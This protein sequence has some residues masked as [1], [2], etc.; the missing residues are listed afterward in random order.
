ME[1]LRL[2]FVMLNGLPSMEIYGYVP[3][4]KWF[5]AGIF[6]TEFIVKSLYNYE[7]KH[8]FSRNISD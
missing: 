1:M 3:T 8:F 4:C 7:I 5:S 6:Q 2:T